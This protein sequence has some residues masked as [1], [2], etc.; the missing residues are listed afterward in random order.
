MIVF[1]IIVAVVG[2]NWHVASTEVLRRA[3][4]PEGARSL[5]VRGFLGL[6][7]G[8]ILIVGGIVV[9]LRSL[10]RRS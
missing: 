9:G 8:L 5:A 1:G 7:L 6:L 10:N 4:D 2:Y 3:F